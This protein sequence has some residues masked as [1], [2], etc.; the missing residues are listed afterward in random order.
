MW[1]MWGAGY[2]V[3]SESVWKSACDTTLCWPSISIDD[4][5]EYDSGREAGRRSPRWTLSPVISRNHL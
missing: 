3:D 2:V 1:A 5:Y 4:E